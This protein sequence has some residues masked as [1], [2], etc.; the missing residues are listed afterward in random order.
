MNSERGTALIGTLAI[1]F[2]FVL[3]ISQVLVTVGRLGAAS[4]EVS[5]VAAY[6]AQYGVRYGGP[7]DAA[8]IARDLMPAADV[9]A[10]TSGA[11]LSIEIRI[12]VPLVGPAGSPIHQTVTGRATTA[13]SPYRSH[14]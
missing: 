12:N 5:E 14:P 13:F 2:V 3:V 6:A 7:D 8:R 4:A 1:G 9:V 10:T 11:S